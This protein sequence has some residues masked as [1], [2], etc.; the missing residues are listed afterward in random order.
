ML[1]ICLKYEQTNYGSKLQALATVEMLKQLGLD[2]EI[3][4]Y[5]KNLAFYLK[6]LPRFFNTVFL[7]DRYDQ[8]QRRIEYKKRP[9]VYANVCIRNQAF[10]AFNTHFIEN[11]S[12]K[13]ESY[14]HLKSSCSAKYDCILS[15]S[16]QLWSPAALGSGFYNMMFAPENMRKVSWA[17]SFGVSDIPWYQ[18]ARTAQYLRRIQHISM[19]ENRGAEIVKELTGRD[20]PVLMDP[21]F[22]FDKEKWDTMVPVDKPEWENYIFCY[23]LGDNQMHREAARELAKRTGK[24]IVTLRHLDR[25]VAADETFGDYAPYDVDPRRFLNIIRNADYICTDSFHGTAFSVLYEKKF[26]VFNRYREDSSNSKNSRIDSLCANLN[27]EN[28]RFRK[29]EDILEAMDNEIAFAEVRSRLQR[30]RD[31]TKT[32]LAETL[33]CA[34]DTLTTK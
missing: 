24:K 9:E 8:I 22:V 30:Y 10:E 11:L 25:Y 13:Y 31:K 28:R 17:S 26:L 14:G 3:I 27:L 2:Y 6:S 19:R 32:Y 18:R 1:G 16:D 4:R 23:F 12:E 34:P 29:N 7:N 15:C 21:V 20:V 5:R 33:G